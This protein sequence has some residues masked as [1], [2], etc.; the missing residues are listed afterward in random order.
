MGRLRH[1]Y[2]KR[3]GRHGRLHFAA[4]LTIVVVTYLLVPW[5]VNLIDAGRGYNP[6]Y[7]EP[8][9]GSRQDFIIRQGLPAP[10]VTPWKTVVNVVLI[11]AVV[12]VWLR[13]LPRRR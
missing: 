5:I 10:P 2:H 13:L 9:D 1:Y 6:F 8:K 11:A 7:Y 4:L 3:F 12:V